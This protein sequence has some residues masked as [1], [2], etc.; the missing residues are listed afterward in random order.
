MYVIQWGQLRSPPTK[1]IMDEKPLPCVL[2]NLIAYVQWLPGYN[3]MYIILLHYGTRDHDH[4]YVYKVYVHVQLIKEYIC[5][6]NN[7]YTDM[8]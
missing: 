2:S 4:K 3:D 5:M 6:Y 7:L 1:N 8:H